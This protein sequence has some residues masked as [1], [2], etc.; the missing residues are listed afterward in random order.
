VSWLNLHPTEPVR[1]GLFDLPSD[2]ERLAAALCRFKLT[3]VVVSYYEHPALNDLY[4]GWAKLDIGCAK[5]M[6]N[7]GG[8]DGRTESPEVL[9]I[10][11]KDV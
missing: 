10:N 7:V 3:R 2:H 4:P 11:R 9:L 8:R 5:N 6:A 1:G